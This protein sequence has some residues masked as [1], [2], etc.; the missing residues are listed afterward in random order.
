MR[1]PRAAGAGR[2]RTPLL[3]V[4]TSRSESLL[5]LLQLPLRDHFLQEASLDCTLSFWV[6][7]CPVTVSSLSLGSGSD[8]REDVGAHCPLAGWPRRLEDGDGVGKERASPSRNCGSQRKNTPHLPGV[9]RSTTFPGF[10]VEQS[11]RSTGFLFILRQGHRDRV[12]HLE[13]AVRL[14]P[15]HP[16]A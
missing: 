12:L 8:G 16:S 14:S 6:T 5:C 3:S 11:L 9:E 13:S 10:G 4:R 15:E 7:S 2:L 1:K